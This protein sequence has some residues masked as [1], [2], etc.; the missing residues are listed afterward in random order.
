MCELQR[1]CF[2]IIPKL[3]YGH[4]ISVIKRVKVFPVLNAMKIYGGVEV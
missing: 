4:T 1:K 3:P 2:K